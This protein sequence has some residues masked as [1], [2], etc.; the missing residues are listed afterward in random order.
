[1]ESAR[2]ALNLRIA[3]A[4]SHEIRTAFG[5]KRLT[6][7]SEDV[8]ILDSLDAHTLDLALAISTEVAVNALTMLDAN[9]AELIS[10]ASL[11]TLLT[12][13]VD[14]M[15]LNPFITTLLLA[16]AR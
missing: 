8:E 16:L 15:E 2:L 11:S 7:D 1:M 9:I 5:A 13:L 10:L 12:P 6:M 4:A 14:A 3:E